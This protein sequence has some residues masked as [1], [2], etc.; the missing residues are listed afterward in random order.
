MLSNQMLEQLDLAD[1][2]K[3]IVGNFGNN[4]L[5]DTA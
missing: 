4:I 2:G 1:E 5:N 3:T